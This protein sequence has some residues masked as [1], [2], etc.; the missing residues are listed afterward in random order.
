VT[1]SQIIHRW[2]VA[3][4]WISLLSA[5]YF[6]WKESGEGNYLK[7]WIWLATGLFSLNAAIGATYILSWDLEGG[8]FEL[9]SLVHLMLASLT[10]LVLATAWIGCA[11]AKEG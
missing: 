5:S 4:I 1:Q 3:V 8:F 10:F 6:L 7:E 2:F 11:I 9:L